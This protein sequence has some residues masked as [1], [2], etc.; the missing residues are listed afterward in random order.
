MTKLQ[1]IEEL[2][3]SKHL[4]LLSKS[5]SK[6]EKWEKIIKLHKN[7]SF[8]IK[9]L[10]NL[11][12]VSRSGFYKWVKNG[13]SHFNKWDEN[14]EQII[15][16]FYFS[17]NRVYGH[18]MLS[19]LIKKFSNLDLKPWVVYRYMKKLGLFAITRRKRY[20]YNLE[21]GNNKYDNVLNRN[22]V[23]SFF[24]EK[25]VTDITYLHYDNNTMFL[26]IVKDLYSGKILDFQISDN[27]D[28]QFVYTNIKNS[29]SQIDT[30]IQPILH[31]DQGLHYTSNRYATLISELGFIP[32]M[33]RKGN[34]PDNGACETFFASLKTEVIYIKPRS[35]WTKKSMIEA[36]IDYIE[37]YNYFRPQKRLNWE[38]P[39]DF[40]NKN[41]SNWIAF[42][43]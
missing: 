19:H 35:K 8:S 42:V 3:K 27:L 37:F 10:C 12:N 7:Y 14:L 40:L 6:K 38:S 16:I 15:K 5:L 26:S 30:N 23:A 43:N 4:D 17:F 2:Q 41:K 22:F 36:V 39:Q 13:Q 11:A 29:I 18:Q 31:S 34:S 9:D 25:L 20:K 32:S 1:L 24:G 21:S 28:L 33:S